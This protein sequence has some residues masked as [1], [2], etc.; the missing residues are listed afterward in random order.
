VYDEDNLAKKQ[1]KQRL[2]MW[3]SFQKGSNSD[4]VTCFGCSA[5]YFE[6]KKQS[7]FLDVQKNSELFSLY[8]P[9]IRHGTI[10]YLYCEELGIVS[11]YKHT[12]L[13]TS[14]A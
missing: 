2:K 14:H 10:L 5:V 4:A 12:D 11:R 7:M 9:W 13:R 3:R 1:L 6:K 8:S